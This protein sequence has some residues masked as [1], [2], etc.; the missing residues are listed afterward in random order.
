M[1]R[2][3]ER[4]RRHERCGSGRPP[5]GMALDVAKR[6]YVLETR[7]IALTD[8]AKALRQSERVRKTHLGE[9]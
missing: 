7:T 5:V 1:R 3:K 2:P 6:G 9:E 8:D 4:P